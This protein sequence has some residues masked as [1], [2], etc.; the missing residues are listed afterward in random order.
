MLSSIV[1]CFYSIPQR[2]DVIKS[3]VASY[4]RYLKDITCIPMQ[5]SQ[6]IC[7]HHWAVCLPFTFVFCIEHSIESA[8]VCEY[9]IILDF[10]NSLKCIESIVGFIHS[11]W[12]HSYHL[13][14]RRSHRSSSPWIGAFYCCWEPEAMGN[15]PPDGQK[16]I[17]PWQ[18]YKVQLRR[19]AYTV[20]WLFF[21][22]D[23]GDWLTIRLRYLKFVSLGH[24]QLHH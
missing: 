22:W 3:K 7:C 15:I 14:K 23:M 19:W 9:L 20:R 18:M 16:Y 17:W 5:L 6:H 2:Y 11:E 4:W 12:V 21:I 8:L 10:S 1:R 24:H 13:D